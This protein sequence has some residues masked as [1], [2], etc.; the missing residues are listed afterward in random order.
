[1]PTNIKLVF[2]GAPRTATTSLWYALKEHEKI[3]IP[4]NKEHIN[5]SSKRELFPEEYIKEFQINENT[6]ILLDGTPCAYNYYHDLVKRIVYNFKFN[7]KIIYPIRNPFDRIYSNIK[8]NIIT[9]HYW[10][11]EWGKKYDVPYIKNGKVDGSKILNFLP[12]SRD[13]LNLY[14]AFDI[15]DDIF[16]FRLDQLNINDIF[17][18]IGIK[19]INVNLKIM[20]QMNKEWFSDEFNNIRMDIDYYWNLYRKE[21]A[22]FI[23]E[24]L[25]KLK[26]SKRVKINVEDWIEQTENILK[27]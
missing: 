21:I 19:P 12:H 23:R 17:K 26:N 4:K 14:Y 24:D 9:Y 1:M 3:A 27:G 11:P 8:Q 10:K 2:L 13:G 22:E 25:Y 15:T 16:I 7:V 18:F 6:E 5:Y 20:N